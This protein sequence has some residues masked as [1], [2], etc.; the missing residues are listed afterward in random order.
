M[1]AAE[2]VQLFVAPTAAMLQGMP[3]G[4]LPKKSLKG[5]A[6]VTVQPGRHQV[7]EL[8]VSSKDFQHA[9]PLGEEAVPRVTA[10]VLL[11]VLDFATAASYTA[12]PS[13]VL[14]GWATRPPAVHGY[15]TDI[16]VNCKHQA[17]ATS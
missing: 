3:A 5:F 2:V 4:T 6:R 9:V 14:L 12:K 13:R 10:S 15:C 7:V 11:H 16:T 17:P 1:E 8:P